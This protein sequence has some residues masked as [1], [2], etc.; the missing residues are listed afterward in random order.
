M[1]APRTRC[2]NRRDRMTADQAAR[3]SC[4]QVVVLACGRAGVRSRLLAGRPAPTAAGHRS[5][6]G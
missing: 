1:L 2:R 6:S 5:V 4:G 3:R